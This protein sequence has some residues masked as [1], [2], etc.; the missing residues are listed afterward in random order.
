MRLTAMILADATG[1]DRPYDE[2]Y[3]GDFGNYQ[4]M[5]H[6]FMDEHLLTIDLAQRVLLSPNQ[7]LALATAQPEYDAFLGGGD[8][9]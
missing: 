3:R 8:R 2:L 4:G 6:R 9:G 1:D 7:V 5:W